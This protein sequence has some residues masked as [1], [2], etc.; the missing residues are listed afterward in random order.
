MSTKA[1][2]QRYLSGYPAA[3]RYTGLSETTLRRLVDAEKLHVYRPTE[4][5]I[6]FD[7]V[8]LDALI[9]GSVVEQTA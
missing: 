3:A 5:K 8:E 1:D 7:R 6:L 2:E 4:R 9:Q